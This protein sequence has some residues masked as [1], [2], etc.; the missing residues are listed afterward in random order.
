M[1]AAALGLRELARARYPV[2]GGGN[3]LPPRFAHREVYP[4]QAQVVAGFTLASSSALG[5]PSGFSVNW[6]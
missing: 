6:G 2:M 5:A 3:D 1:L 4:M